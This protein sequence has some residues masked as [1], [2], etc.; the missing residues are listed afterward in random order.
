MERGFN[1][2][3]CLDN[4]G[5]GLVRHLP[6]VT[7]LER[8]AIS[9]LKNYTENAWN[10]EIF[11][12]ESHL[13]KEHMG[14]PWKEQM[15]S[16]ATL[17]ALKLQAPMTFTEPH[18]NKPTLQN[19]CRL[20]PQQRVHSQRPS[21]S[22]YS[23]WS[24]SSRISSISSGQFPFT[25]SHPQPT[26]P[27]QLPLPH[28]SRIHPTCPGSRNPSLSPLNPGAPTSSQ[29]Q[30][31]K[32]YPRSKSTKSVSWTCLFNIRAVRCLWMRTGMRMLELIWAMLLIVL[33][34]RIGRESFIGIVLRDWMTCL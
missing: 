7:Q 8:T 12:I 14:S 10:Y 16:K 15:S 17:Q 6:M 34:R 23:S 27:I 26:F 29:T 25:S 1:R 20:Q 13:M 3:C 4:A 22:C 32:T 18:Q 33:H 11:E 24:P 30:S 28:L 9:S 2:A 31:S 5:L 21:S 19:S